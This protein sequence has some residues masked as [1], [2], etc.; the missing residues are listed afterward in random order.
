MVNLTFRGSI[1]N[2]K[3]LENQLRVPFIWAEHTWNIHL[4]KNKVSLI[5]FLF[6]KI[7]TA[8]FINFTL[9]LQEIFELGVAY[10]LWLSK[11]W[12]E[13]KK[14]KAIFSVLTFLDS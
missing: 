8:L 3:T 12:I 2:Q 11:C 14:G 13:N 4:N 5:T 10:S 7:N 9:V 6:V 1:H